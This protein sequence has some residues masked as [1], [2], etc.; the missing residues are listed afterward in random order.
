MPVWEVRY[1]HKPGSGLP[2]VKDQAA[3]TVA[4]LLGFEALWV[5]VCPNPV[6]GDV[7]IIGEIGEKGW[8]QLKS[9]DPL[10]DGRE[11]VFD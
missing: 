3:Q 1:N 6:T 5:R 9:A 7:L 2:P 11:I 4:R 10:T 8:R